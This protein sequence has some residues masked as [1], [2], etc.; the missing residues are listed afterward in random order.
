MSHA[1]IYY[2]VDAAQAAR[3]ATRVDALLRALAPYCGKQP[4]RLVRCDDASTW[5]EIYEDIDDWQAFETALQ[6]RLDALEIAGLLDGPRHLE[7][8]VAP[9]DPIGR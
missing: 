7:R 2:R 4:R 5:M 6:G 1:Y 9:A 3:A 8:F